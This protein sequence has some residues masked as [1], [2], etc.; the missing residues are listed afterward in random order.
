MTIAQI[1]REPR[2]QEAIALLRGVLKQVEE[3]EDATEA[4]VLV[5]IG[6]DYHRFTTGIKDM[7]SMIAMLEVAKYD[8]IQ[9]M[10]E[11]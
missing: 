1:K 7:M 6:K 2:N 10:S 5:K 3:N 11:D 8:C 4:L 9:R